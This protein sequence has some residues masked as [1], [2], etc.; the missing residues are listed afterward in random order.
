M[1]CICVYL[2]GALFLLSFDLLC[3]NYV[4]FLC[5]SRQFIGKTCCRRDHISTKFPFIVES[6]PEERHYLALKGCTVETVEMGQKTFRT[7]V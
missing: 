6:A 5:F 7:G 4:D 1:H 2:C 3:I